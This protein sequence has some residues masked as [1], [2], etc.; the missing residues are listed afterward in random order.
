[1]SAISI[2]F[3]F[4]HIYSFSYNILAWLIDKYGLKLNF[5]ISLINDYQA[6]MIDFNNCFLLAG[7]LQGRRRIIGRL[8]VC[9]C[10]KH[11]WII[12]N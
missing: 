3:Y 9:I 7:M 10:N 12:I 2:L 6:S 4:V 8:S 1:M 5:L 11:E